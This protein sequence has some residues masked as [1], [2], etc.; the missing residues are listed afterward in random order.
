M[1]HGVIF[2]L[3]TS[4]DDLLPR[5]GTRAMTGN[6][7]M[8]NNIISN[9]SNGINDTDAAT[10]GQI[11]T[12]IGNNFLSTNGGIVNGNI[13]LNNTGLI[14][15][16]SYTTQRLNVYTN[17]AS[18]TAVQYNV[19][20]FGCP[21]NITFSHLAPNSYIGDSFFMGGILYTNKV[22]V[23]GSVNRAK[24][25][26]VS[27]RD[28]TILNR[29]ANQLSSSATSPLDHLCFSAIF[30][31][32]TGS[33]HIIFNRSTSGEWTADCSWYDGLSVDQSK[34]GYYM[35]LIFIGEVTDPTA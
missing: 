12:L 11:S 29:L 31:F 8:G 14:I 23:S 15:N 21:V 5:D 25:G 2:G 1:A 10:V 18:T 22:G 30:D 24:N 26:T 3:K 28:F 33:S 4:T 27:S 6:L 9:L 16:Q 17:S 34:K 35:P 20:G 7:N 32:G 13:D 19:L